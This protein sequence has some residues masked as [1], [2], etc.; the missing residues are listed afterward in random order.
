MR[1]L[2]IGF[3]ASLILGSCNSTTEWKLVWSDEFDTDG[4]VDSTKWSYDTK[5]NAWDWGNNELQYYT[6]QE[7]NNAWVENGVLKIQARKDSI[8]GKNYSSARL[9]THGKASFTYGKFEISAKLPAGRGLWPAIWM[10]SDSIEHKG[11]PKSGE[12]DIMEHVGYQPDSIY[13]TIHSE[14]YNHLKKTEKTKA[15]YI[16]DPY[17]EFHVYSMEWSPEK[18]EFFVDGTLFNTVVNENISENEWPFNHPFY[19]LLNLAVGG[20]WGGKMGIDTT[21]FPATMEVDYVRVYEKQ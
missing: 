17:T 7:G 9:K 18:I 6:E 16:A 19:L 15:I 3:F 2:I 8:G 1:L 20:N 10:L 11:W 21:V 4:A 13:G 12:I 5:G 14:T